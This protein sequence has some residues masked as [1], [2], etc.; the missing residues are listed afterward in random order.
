MD[1]LV[2]GLTTQ[3]PQKMDT[4]VTEEVCNFLFKEEGADFGQDLMA[5]NIQ[6]IIQQQQ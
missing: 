6:V 3:S 1:R 4:H 5:R 2:K